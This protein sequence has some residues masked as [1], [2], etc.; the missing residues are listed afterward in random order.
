MTRVVNSRIRLLLLC[1]LLTF[2]ALLARAAW[3]ST[4]RAS[5][6]SR[7]GQVQTKAPVV[8]PAGRGTIFDSAGAPL[9]LGEQATTIYVDPHEV[10][11]PT[12]EARTAAR[13]LGLKVIDVYHALTVKR[14][15]FS[16][17]ERKAPPDRAAALAQKKLVGFHFYGEERRT[18]PQHSVAAPVLG[19]AGVDNVGL[20][21]LELQLNSSL[22]G[23]PGEQ[24]VVQD[25][26]GQAISVAHT[27]AARPGKAVF[28]TLDHTIQANAEQV[29][30]QTIAQWGGEARDG[31]RP[32]SENR[33]HSRDG[34][35]ADARRERLGD[36]AACRRTTRSP[37]CS[38]RAP[39]SRS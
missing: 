24:T 29:L 7:I 2:G 10:R 14:T 4:V 34:R 31:D 38:S 26:F 27:V 11:R 6:L 39:C 13:V 19:F 5:S 12:A 8:I 36:E 18:Y 30:R 33:R 23:K 37:T 28:L 15:H 25:P 16:F 17:V 32:R 22:A 1:I 20:S 35:S 9:A 21:G 3:I